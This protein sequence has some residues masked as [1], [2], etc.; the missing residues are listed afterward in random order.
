MLNLSKVKGNEISGLDSDEISFMALLTND[1]EDEVNQ[2]NGLTDNQLN[3]LC[4]VLNEYPEV[5]DSLIEEM[6]VLEDGMKNQRTKEQTQQF[7]TKFKMFLSSQNLPDNIETMPPRYLNQYLRFWYSKL[8]RV[9]GQLYSP[10]SLICFRAAIHRYITSG[11]VGRTF[12]IMHDS[13]FNAANTMLKCMIG[14]YLKT[15]R[16]NHNENGISAIE[17]SDLQLLRKYFDRSN[18][19]ILQHEVFWNII[20]HFGFRG[21][22]WIRELNKDSIMIKTDSNGREFIDLIRPSAE[23]NVKPSL[24][25]RHFESNKNIVMYAT[26]ESPSTCPVAAIKLYFQKMPNKIA[27]L[28]PRHKGKPKANEWKM[29]DEWY[30]TTQVHGKHYLI[31]MMKSISLSAKLSRVYTNHCARATVVTEL[32]NKGHSISDIQ[33]V[34]GH[35][36]ADSVQR[37]IKNITPSK[38]MKLSNDLQMSMC[39]SSISTVPSNE[40]EENSIINNVCNNSFQ[41]KICNK[42]TEE[43]CSSVEKPT[44]VLRKNGAILEFFL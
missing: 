23:K 32:H 19:Q 39:S 1:M 38:K 43:Q 8:K 18:P 11:S 27:C 3:E 6:N 31:N 20:Y 16:S 9:D 37:Y 5:D 15:N 44:A 4:D 21:R 35:K 26:P 41:V 13:E 28:F 2:F 12:N 30:S 34:T 33:C 10:S 14:Q 40:L 7:V 24:S 36:R 25:R 17:A 29:E 22:E 42:R